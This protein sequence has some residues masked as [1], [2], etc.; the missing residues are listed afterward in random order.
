[1]G[2]YYI[3]PDF[4]YSKVFPLNHQ[5]YLLFYYNLLISKEQIL[6]ALIC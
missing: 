4:L 3:K 6:I 2:W 5:N 1:M